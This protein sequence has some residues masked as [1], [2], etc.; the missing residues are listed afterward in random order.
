MPDS[1]GADSVFRE[2]QASDT[3]A[4]DTLK[5]AA[6]KKE[7]LEDEVIY[8]AEDSMIISVKNQR[9]YLYGQAKVKY[10][11]INL[12]AG[13]IEFDMKNQEVFARGKFDTD[14]F[15]SLKSTAN[16]IQCGILFAPSNCQSAYGHDEGHQV[17]PRLLKNG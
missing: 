16:Q 1:V 6:K 11:D 8:S 3:T 12:D 13:Y 9:M 15:Q 10:Q 2:V 4:S 17:V 5:P 7:V 14:P